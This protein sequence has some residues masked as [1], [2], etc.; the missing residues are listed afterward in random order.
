MA[1]G[2]W[3]G[4][5][6]FGHTIV[7]LAVL[8]WGGLI[9]ALMWGVFW[10]WSRRSS[11]EWARRGLLITRWLG[12]VV[13]VQALALPIGSWVG[14][15]DMRAAK[16]YCESI[17]TEL[18]AHRVEYGCYPTEAQFVDV[19][20]DGEPH[21]LRG[22]R[23]YFGSCEGFSFQIIDPRVMLGSWWFDG[24]DREWRYVD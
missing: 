10:P 7:T 21:L 9:S 14:D 13:V 11:S 15:R 20:R 16:T 24:E 1:G 2:C 23:Y 18:E 4:R 6:S 17:V 8:L 5:G 12:V 19:P 3:V 22:W